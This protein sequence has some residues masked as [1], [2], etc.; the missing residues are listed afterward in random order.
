MFARR[1][2]PRRRALGQ[3]AE[4]EA[5]AARG[6]DDAVVLGLDLGDRHAPAGGRFLLEHH[7]GR[8]GDAAKRLEMMAHAAR[9]V[10][11]LVAEARLVALRLQDLYA[12]QIRFQ[13]VGHHHG[14]AGA[15]ALAHLGADAQEI[16]R[17]VIGDGEEELRIVL[18]SAGHAVAAKFLLLRLSRRGKADREHEG[19]RSESEENRAARD[20][21]DFC[22]VGHGHALPYALPEARLMA[23]RMR[24]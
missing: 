15:D 10:G 1:H 9:A 5:P 16:D 6:M 14:P 13:L 7:A 23:S 2:R 17:P 8:R 22:G 12:T 18:H 19:S 24:G 20:V 4:I 3:R 11:V 21:R